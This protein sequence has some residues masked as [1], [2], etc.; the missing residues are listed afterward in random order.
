LGPYST[1]AHTVLEDKILVSVG[2]FLAG[3]QGKMFLETWILF[4]GVT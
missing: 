1:K 4:Q 3:E 2:I